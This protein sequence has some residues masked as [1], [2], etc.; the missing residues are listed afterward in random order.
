MAPGILRIKNQRHESFVFPRLIES[1][2]TKK[3]TIPSHMKAMLGSLGGI[4]E[5]CCLQAID[6]IKTRL[7]LDRT[8][9]GCAWGK[10]NGGRVLVSCRE[11]ENVVGWSWGNN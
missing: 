2:T 10:K 7:Q 3:A 1:R 9:G 11:I 6:V 5:A 8:R 4:M